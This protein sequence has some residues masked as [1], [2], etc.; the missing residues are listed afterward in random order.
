VSDDDAETNPDPEFSGGI[1]RYLTDAIREAARVISV[2]TWTP[3]PIRR[4]RWKPALR[5]ANANLE[6]LQSH[7]TN[8]KLEHSRTH[9]FF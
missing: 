1:D 2:V 8:S 7:T 4:L 3:T 6:R 5:N 9:G